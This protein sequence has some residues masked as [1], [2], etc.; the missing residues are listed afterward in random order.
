MCR[1][2]E[3]SEEVRLL[4]LELQ[5]VVNCHAEPERGSLQGHEVLVTPEPS[6]WTT[7]KVISSSLFGLE[8]Q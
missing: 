4:D 6:L 5:T 2:L 3:K 8:I 7:S 1:S